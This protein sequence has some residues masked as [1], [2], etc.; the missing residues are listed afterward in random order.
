MEYAHNKVNG[1]ARDRVGIAAKQ[2]S[3]QFLHVLLMYANDTAR[4]KLS[5]GDEITS[6]VIR[7]MSLE[8]SMDSSILSSWNE[9]FG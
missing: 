2:F 4:W 5:V 3:S 1:V 6:M 8:R 9:M 7:E